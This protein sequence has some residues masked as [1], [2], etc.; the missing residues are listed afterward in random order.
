MSLCVGSACAMLHDVPVKVRR[1]LMGVGSVSNLGDL[2]GP[3][4]VIRLHS[5]C[6]PLLDN[7]PS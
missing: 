3:A 2:G 5:I 7:P 1:Q 6:M 4:Q